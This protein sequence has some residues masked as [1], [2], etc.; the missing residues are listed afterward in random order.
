MKLAKYICEIILPPIFKRNYHTMQIPHLV[1]YKFRLALYNIS[2]YWVFL[3]LSP[4]E[5]SFNIV[6]LLKVRGFSGLWNSFYSGCGA[7]FGNMQL[8]AHS[9]FKEKTSINRIHSGRIFEVFNTLNNKVTMWSNRSFVN[10][11]R[12]SGTFLDEW[13]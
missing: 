2:L 8:L 6:D 4:S 12:I 3:M 11:E 13:K 1:H 5:I 7:C 10:V 9:H